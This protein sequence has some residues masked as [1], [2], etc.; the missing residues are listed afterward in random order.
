[1]VG[2]HATWV[3]SEA[4]ETGPPQIRV[5]SVMW[6]GS[7]AELDAGAVTCECVLIKLFITIFDKTLSVQNSSHIL[8]KCVQAC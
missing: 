6:E 4:V 7:E 2:D 8:G 5:V 1:M 3:L